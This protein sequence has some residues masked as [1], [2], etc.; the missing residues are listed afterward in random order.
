LSLASWFAGELAAVEAR[1]LAVPAERAALPYRPGGWTRQ[2]V[3]GHLVDSA[4]NNHVRFAGAATNPRFE[5]LFGYEADGWVRVHGY[6]QMSWED[7]L[8]HW[9]TQNELLARVVE[10]VKPEQVLRAGD[11]EWVM[12]HWVRDYIRHMLHHVEQITR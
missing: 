5:M 6:G 12:E 8:R 2:E 11:T 3:L 10:H 4:I 7:V 9:R 1:L